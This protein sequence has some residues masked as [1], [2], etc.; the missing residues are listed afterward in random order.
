MKNYVFIL[1]ALLAIGL[2]IAGCS[3]K[4]EQLPTGA[5]V[6]VDVGID[7]GNFVKIPVSEITDKAKFY[8]FDAD[9]VNVNY[10]AVR[11]SDGKIRTAFDACDVCG[12]S[13]GYRQEG[14]DM[15]CNNCGRFFDIDS[16]GTANKGGG[17]WPSFLSNTI[18]GDYV[19][20]SKLDLANGAFRFR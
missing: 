12:G 6:G 9:G 16:I 2:L 14:D 19:K 20:I 5:A 17:C 8:S 11:G 7:E 10:F 13:K 1:M 18:E 4:T 3:S 15:V